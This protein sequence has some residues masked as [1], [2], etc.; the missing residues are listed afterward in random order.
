[1]ATSKGKTTRTAK[2]KWDAQSILRK[3][4]RWIIVLLLIFSSSLVWRLYELS[5]DAEAA[6]DAEELR[7]YEIP[8]LASRGSILDRNGTLL[9]TSLDSD[10]LVVS[11]SLLAND[12]ESL[13]NLSIELLASYF[14]PILEMDEEEVYARL[15]SP[16]QQVYLK[17]LME[18]EMT[19]EIMELINRLDLDGFNLIQEPKR[20]YPWDTFAA[21]ILG[22]SGTEN[23]GL[24]GLEL[25][26]NEQL[27]GQH[28]L[29]TRQQDT[30]GHFIPDTPF[31]RESANDGYNLVLT[32]D[33]RIQTFLEKTLERYC[34]L[35]EGEGGGAIVL[36][37]HTGEILGMASYPFFDPNNYNDYPSE[38]RTNR[39]VHD[40][41]E[42]GSTFKLV[43][44]LAALEEGVVN[45]EDYFDDPGALHVAG[46]TISNWDGIWDHGSL[47]FR[48]AM[49]N[50][51]NVVLAQVGQL[52]GAE[53]L[54]S[55]H[56]LL[57]FGSPTGI[58]FPDES[59]G[60]IFSVEEMGPSELV[61]AAFGQG[62]AV[63]PIQ[64]VMAIAAVANGGKLIQPHLALELR[65]QEGQTVE[66]VAPKVLREVASPQTMQRMRD[67]MEYIIN[68]PG[69][70]GASE[71][72]RLAGKTGTASKI[73]PDKEGYLEDSYIASTI[74]FA[75]AD[76]PL[77]VIYFYI[78]DPKGPNGFYGGQ[79]AAPAFRE[80]AEALLVDD[81]RATL[82]NE[83]NSIYLP[84]NIYQRELL[85]VIGQT[86]ESGATA[87][88]ELRLQVISLGEG[89]HILAQYPIPEGTSTTY[90]SVSQPVTLY[91]GDPARLAA[92]E[93]IVPDFTG[94]TMK[95]V[96]S[97]TSQLGLNHWYNGE[98]GV[99][100]HQEPKA[101]ELVSKGSI[102]RVSYR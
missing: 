100:Y 58:D 53:R 97:V 12:L 90:I 37:P 38:N 65:N 49:R 11:P 41:F 94:K 98:S 93:I 62:P 56:H 69:S 48:N 13:K 34:Q 60:I 28:G 39:I 99:S 45:E 59:A 5:F 76:D 16:M 19:A 80:I 84:A 32:L 73:D 43:T 21:S 4:L 10:T 31:M 24:E 17:R 92:G 23:N 9:A 22:I 81:N 36:D 51:S 87:L 52:L 68:A 26:Y 101:G 44:A 46:F 86:A 70:K 7:T 75:P 64:Q 33:H 42:P 40:A 47:S 82:L 54:S 91:L 3:R 15:T 96:I 67:L 27:A 72:Y 61:T 55:Y 8:I 35:N 50:S 25:C 14:A 102:I 18:P 29:F 57:G 6:Q 83:T 89:E 78:D 85:R 63:T 66:K 74:G 71:L 88:D 95:E 20:Y 79:V 2:G 1:M 77:Y 30:S